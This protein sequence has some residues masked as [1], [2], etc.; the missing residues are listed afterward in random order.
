[1]S[2]VEDLIFG[3]FDML[4]L[5]PRLPLSAL[6]DPGDLTMNGALCMMKAD[7]FIH[8]FS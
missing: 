4:W 7:E 2:Y 6:I 1:M 3:E 5:A 8:E